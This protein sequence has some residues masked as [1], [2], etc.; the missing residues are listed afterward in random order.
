MPRTQESPVKRTQLSLPQRGLRLGQFSPKMQRVGFK[1]MEYFVT[2][3]GEIDKTEARKWAWLEVRW[4][5]VEDRSACFM[6]LPLMGPANDVRPQAFRT[7]RCN[8]RVLLT[9]HICYPFSTPECIRMIAHSW[10]HYK[11]VHVQSF[12][13]ED[14]TMTVPWQ[15]D[16][17]MLNSFLYPRSSAM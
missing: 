16:W 3:T 10:P 1:E 12:M 14:T 7:E 5:S 13:K 4:R 8:T 2:E 6:V 11:H 15:S 9:D 17:E